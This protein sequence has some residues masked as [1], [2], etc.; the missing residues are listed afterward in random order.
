M[1]PTVVLVMNTMKIY[2][3]NKMK[4]LRLYRRVKSTLAVKFAD[5][6]DTS[7]LSGEGLIKEFGSLPG[8]NSTMTTGLNRCGAI[9]IKRLDSVSSV[10]LRGDYV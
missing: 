7:L 2:G 9:L 5:L 3:K 1:G 10:N 8:R 6:R 4:S